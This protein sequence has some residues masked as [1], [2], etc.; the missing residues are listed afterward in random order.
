MKTPFRD[1]DIV[2]DE[3]SMGWGEGPGQSNHTDDS[4]A[5]QR[6]T[7]GLSPGLLRLGGPKA[8]L[9]SLSAVPQW[10]ATRSEGVW[11]QIGDAIRNTFCW[12]Q[13][14]PGYNTRAP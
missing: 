9:K 3:P 2:D 7:E 4:E 1:L 10:N 11:A 13:S 12:P 14:I 5:E 8:S 6:A